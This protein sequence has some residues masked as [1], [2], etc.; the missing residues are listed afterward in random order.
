TLE[1]TPEERRHVRRRSWAL[2]RQLAGPVKGM[3]WLTVVLVVVSN[4]ARAAVPLVIAWAI[5]WGLPQVVEA[6]RTG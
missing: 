1:Y 6:V 3:L 2:L 4:A 5:D